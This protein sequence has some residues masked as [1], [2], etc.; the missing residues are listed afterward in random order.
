MTLSRRRV[1]GLAAAAAARFSTGCARA[2]RPNVIIVQADDLRATATRPYNPQAVQLPNLD[3]LAGS[4]TVFDHCY[5]PHPLCC[6]ARVSLWSGQYSSR[7]GSRHNQQL[8]SA[9]T[10][11]F[12][13]AFHQAGYT[14]GIFG[15][16]HCFAPPQ[17]KQWFETDFSFAS[18]AWRSA[19]SPQTSKAIA[20]HANWLRAQGGALLPPA[21]APFPYQIFPTH[22]ATQHAIDF[23]NR[24]PDNPFLLWVSLPDPHTPIEVPEEF[25]SALPLKAVQLPPFGK[26]QFDRKNT[27]MR[28]YDYLIRGR[29]LPDEYLARYLSIYSGKTAFVDFELGRL[30]STLDATRLREDTIVVF[31][32]DNGDFAAEHHLIVKTGSMVDAMV[33]QPLVISWP[34]SLPSGR[35]LPQL[36]NQID[37]L[38]TLA[39]L[40][41]IPPLPSAQGTPLLFASS[42]PGREFVYSEYGASH[43]DYTWE[44]ARTVGPAARLGD[45][46]LATPL[47]LHH[48]ERRERAGHL[49]MIRTP[50]HKLIADSNGDIEFYDLARDPHELANVHATPPYKDHERLLTDLLA[51]QTPSN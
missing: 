41:G 47:E 37:I 38:P 25:A 36:V 19:I 21:A 45:Y 40:C 17:L 6:P 10:P 34:G 43:A 42:A 39:Q 50:T 13:Q 18:A 48:L 22:I 23:L 14:L 7:H 29:E 32:S 27:R 46:A 30:L 3:R 15:K 28:I 1:T 8:M 12:A 33:R 20:D 26:D 51:R 24:P 11:N 31:T 4:G 44:E 2:P 5:T 9:V 49:R 35:R 16:N